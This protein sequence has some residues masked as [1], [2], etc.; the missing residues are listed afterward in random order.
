[1]IQNIL[2]HA[3]WLSLYKKSYKYYQQV[4]LL[5]CFAFVHIQG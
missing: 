1:M 4:T 2:I 3:Y 5:V